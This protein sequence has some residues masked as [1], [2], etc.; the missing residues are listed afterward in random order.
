MFPKKKKKTFHKY[1]CN[2][3]LNKNLNVMYKKYISL[4]AI[5][6]LHYLLTNM[7]GSVC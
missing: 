6:L 4:Y 5:I 3:L 1:N 2:K 7:T